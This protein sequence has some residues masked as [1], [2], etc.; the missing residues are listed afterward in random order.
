MHDGF[1]PLD[2]ALRATDVPG[3]EPLSEAATGSGDVRDG[4]T[5]TNSA[6]LGDVEDALAAARRFNAALADALALSLERL[7]RDIACDV[8]ARE[9][10]L[11][12]CDVAAVAARALQRYAGEGALRLRVHPGDVAACAALEVPVVGDGSLRTGDVI[13]DVRCGSIDASLGARLETLLS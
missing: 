8:L 5:Q 11:A 7:V 10:L 4:R 9:L 12:P 6:G 1:V 3:S 13:L 2:V